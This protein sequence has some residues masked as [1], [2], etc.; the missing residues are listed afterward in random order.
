MVGARRSSRMARALLARSRVALFGGISV[1]AVAMPTQAVA[2]PGTAGLLA[3][4]MHPLGLMHMPTSL[5][6]GQPSCHKPSAQFHCYLPA[7]IRNAYGIEPL[8]DHGA[9]GAGTTIAIVDAFQNPTMAQDLA[10]FDAVSGLPAPPSFRILAPHGLTQFDPN[11]PNQVGWSAEIALD[12]EWAHAIAPAANIV[13][14]LAPG[15][16]DADT[17]QAEEYV[18]SHRLADV[19][20]MSYI[21]TEQ[22]EPTNVRSQEHAAF[23]RATREGMTLVAGSGDWGAAQ[24]TCD[25]NSFIKAVGVPA[26]DPLV[27][28]VGGTT[29]HAN[30][31]TGRYQDEVVWNEGTDNGAGGGGFSALYRRPSYQAAIEAPGSM[32]GVPDVAY[33]A[34]A[35]WGVYV[36]WGSSGQPGPPDWS[37]SGTSCGPPQWSGIVSIADQLAGHELGNINPTLYQVNSEDNAFHDI[38]IGDNTF[39]QITGYQAA[40]GWD[41]ASGLGSPIAVNLIPRLATSSPSAS[42]L[43]NGATPAPNVAASG[44][45]SKPL[46]KKT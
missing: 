40:D 4:H 43:S 32:R 1:L 10:R 8:L 12:V 36:A 24:F 11:D 15:S 23:H 19:L 29:L 35:F 21:D 13:L 9:D 6:N 17:A 26:S 45:R 30:L 18:I 41:P 3:H 14:V 22:C 31:K 38:T 46:G 44:G 39:G 16:S 5:S 27:T 28:A 2:S 33:N 34:S 42:E 20:S 25:G 37:F 7:Q